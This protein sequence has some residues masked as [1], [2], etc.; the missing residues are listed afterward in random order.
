MLGALSQQLGLGSLLAELTTRFGGYDLVDHWQQGEFH[1]DLVLRVPDGTPLP[2][3]FLLVATNCNGGIKELLCFERAPE[4]QALWHHR[5]PA[6][7][8]FAGDLPPLLASAR[9][10]H[11]FDPCELLA[12]DARS[13]YREDARERQPGGGWQLKSEPGEA[14]AHCRSLKPSSTT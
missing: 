5:C 14:G 8:E 12:E 2:G 9:T 7:P 10:V 11:W 1:H 13:E 6:S 4:R 3:P